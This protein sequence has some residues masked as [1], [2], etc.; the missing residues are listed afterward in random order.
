M[1]TKSQKVRL[2]VFLVVAAFLLVVALVVVTAPKFLEKRDRYYIE[3]AD[4]S[5]GGLDAGTP[6]KYH[7]I[8]VGRVE[9]VYVDPEDIT[10]IKVVVS[11]RKDTPIKTDTEAVIASIGITGLKYIELTGGTKEAEKVE[12]GGQI[13]AG[14]SLF[15]SLSDRSEVILS[16]IAAFTDEEHRRAFKHTV[17]SIERLVTQVNALIEE[18]R[19][20]FYATARNASVLSESLIQVSGKMERIVAGVN[21]IVEG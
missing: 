6:V 18:N 17:D 1:I 19:E 13:A 21:R 9:D 3:Y 15:E 12:P 11:L 7:G 16:N 14:Q 8:R 20:Q 2:G 5:V 4:V 10:K